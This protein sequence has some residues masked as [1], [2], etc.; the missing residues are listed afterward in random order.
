MPR[1]RRF[2]RRKQVS[3]AL[4]C[5][6]PVQPQRPTFSLAG[7]G[8]VLIGST[9]ACIAVG[10]LV[11]WAAG[12]IRYGLAFGAVVGIPAGVATTVIKYRNI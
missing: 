12:S 1:V 11:G 10:T 9:A 5:S 3:Q 8:S 2:R 4:V 7:A 6:A